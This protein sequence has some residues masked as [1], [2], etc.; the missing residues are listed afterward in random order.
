M[1]EILIDVLIEL[2]EEQENIS[3]DDNFN[4]VKFLKDLGIDAEALT[5]S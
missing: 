3:A 5:I 2:I 4:I 1:D